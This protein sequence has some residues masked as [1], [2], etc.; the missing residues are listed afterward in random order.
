MHV[1]I[2]MAGEGKRFKGSGLGEYKPFVKVAGK[3]LVKRTVES[4]HVDTVSSLTFGIRDTH[5]KKFLVSSNLKNWWPECK[6]VAMGSTRGN[7][8]TCY[9]MLA[10]SPPINDSIVFIDCDNPFQNK[11]ILLDCF[12]HGEDICLLGFKD[13]EK[14]GKWCY[15]QHEE[16]NVTSVHEKDCSYTENVPTALIGF[17]AYKTSDL[18]VQLTQEIIKDNDLVKGE[19]Y[20]SQSVK[21]ALEKGL[22]VRLFTVENF[23]PMGTANDVKKANEN[24]HRH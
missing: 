7:L 21:K 8:E 9:N 18:F 4:L 3:E 5:E 24:M 16:N 2:P 23:I 14:S 12:S 17:F 20:I 19:L 11:N 6:I 22:K 13:Y 15:V 10:S 1:M